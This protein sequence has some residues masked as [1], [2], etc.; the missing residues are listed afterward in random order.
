MRNLKIINRAIKK[1]N[2]VMRNKS[3]TLGEATSRLQNDF[4]AQKL[5]V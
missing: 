1:N 2:F 3:E 5:L 4:M